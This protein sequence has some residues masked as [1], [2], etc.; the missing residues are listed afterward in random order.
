MQQCR[1]RS[2]EYPAELNNHFL[3]LVIHFNR[4]DCSH[5][6]SYSVSVGQNL[7]GLSWARDSVESILCNSL[8]VFWGQSTGWGLFH[9]TQSQELPQ[10][11]SLSGLV[12]I[13]FR[14]VR[15]LLWQLNTLGVTIPALLVEVASPFLISLLVAQCYF[16][17][18][19]AISQSQT[20]PDSGRKNETPPLDGRV[21]RLQKKMW[22]KKYFCRQSITAVWKIMP[23]DLQ[24]CLEF[25]SLLV[26]LPK[27]FVRLAFMISFSLS[28]LIC[29]LG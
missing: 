5:C 2:A 1:L 24:F 16:L 8:E 28:C 18:L 26:L 22:D 10:F 6:Q 11:T 14:A 21:A 12:W 17:I 23:S 19:L 20:C 15:L 29:E 25:A 9:F 27:S 3:P 13:S 4:A 7:E